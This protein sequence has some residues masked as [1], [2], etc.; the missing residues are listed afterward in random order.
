MQSYY[1]P[2]GKF[3]PTSFLYFI[4]TALL[5]VPIISLI[6]AYLIWYI[7][8]IYFNFF[9][10]IGF[11]FLVGFAISMLVVKK[12][13][14]RNKYLAGF[15]GLLAAIVATYFDFVVYVDLAI[16]AGEL[17]GDEHLGISVSNIKILDIFALATQPEVLWTYIKE[18]NAI[19]TWGIKGAV[20]SGSFLTFVWI[21]EFIMVAGVSVF[22]NYITAKDPFCE[23]DNN[24]YKQEDLP[25]FNYIE[26]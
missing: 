17:I 2:S 9:I 14:V 11:G 12:G 18:I 23:L 10:T 24:W 16:N 13:K 7:P 4:P 5:I 6:Y 19:G 1:K 25:I 15:L 26:K 8:F 22:V 21:V 3:S 20:A